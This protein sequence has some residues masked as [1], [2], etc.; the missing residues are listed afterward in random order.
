[1]NK[2]KTKVIV[3]VVIFIVSSFWGLMRHSFERGSGWLGGPVHY[4]YYYGEAYSWEPGYDSLGGF[5][6]GS[7]P[8]T[9]CGALYLDTFESKTRKPT[10]S[11]AYVSTE[12]CK[13]FMSLAEL[14]DRY[15]NEVVIGELRIK[16]EMPDE[17]AQIKLFNE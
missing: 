17:E 3:L 7:F 4:S 12:N 9:K 15:S 14:V 8:E 5:W 10:E 16:R 11:N 13:R 6:R 2:Y 1:M